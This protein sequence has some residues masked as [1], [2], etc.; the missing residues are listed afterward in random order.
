MAD[1]NADGA[2]GIG[3]SGG[4]EA[5]VPASAR[6]LNR[7]PRGRHETAGALNEP[8]RRIHFEQPK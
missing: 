8:T 2:Y 3:K 4:M 7:Q 6:S 5:E 1:T